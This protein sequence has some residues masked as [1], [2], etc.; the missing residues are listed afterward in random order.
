MRHQATQNQ[1]SAAIQQQKLNILYNASN[2]FNLIY[3]MPPAAE[4]AETALLTSISTSTMH[5]P[6]RRSILLLS[7]ISTFQE[8]SI[9]DLSQQ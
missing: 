1:K 4:T 9:P 2:P 5:M 6:G 8:G 3:T 7:D